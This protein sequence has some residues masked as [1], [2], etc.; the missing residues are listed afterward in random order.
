MNFLYEIHRSTQ[1]RILQYR[2]KTQS[3]KEGC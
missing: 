2:D 3:K 1:H